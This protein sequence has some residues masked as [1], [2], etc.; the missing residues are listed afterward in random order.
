MTLRPI[1]DAVDHIRGPARGPTL[2]VYGDYECPYTRKAMRE[3]ERVQAGD[4][5]VRL[6]FRHFPLTE[7]HPHALAAAAAAEAAA[8]Q[9]RFWEMHDLL[10]HRQRALGD[11]DLTRYA[12]ELDLDGARFARD[13]ASAEVF[14]RISRDVDS[15]VAAGV[16]GT[17]AFFIA[18]RAYEGSYDAAELRRA[19]A[20][21]A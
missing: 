21:G 19:L 14:A 4:E 20:A 8:R 6:V 3:I 5:R 15:G 9:E 18:G 11:D 2:L 10:F 1:D 17:P 16:Q 7:I 12:A 13:R